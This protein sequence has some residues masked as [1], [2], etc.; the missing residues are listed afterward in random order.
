MVLVI[1]LVQHVIIITGLQLGLLQHR[2][3]L[4]RPQFVHCHGH[5]IELHKVGGRPQLL[6]VLGDL[7]VKIAEVDFPLDLLDS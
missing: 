7:S 6:F 5:E 2:Q 3:G 1:L 4:A